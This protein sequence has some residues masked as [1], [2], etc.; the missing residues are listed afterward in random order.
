MFLLAQR[1]FFDLFGRPVKIRVFGLDLAHFSETSPAY[2]F[3]YDVI[4]KIV[5]FLHLDE[6]IPFH[7]DLFV[8]LYLLSFLN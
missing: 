8:L 5:L 2:F 4:I 1:R 6:T 7:L 3:Q